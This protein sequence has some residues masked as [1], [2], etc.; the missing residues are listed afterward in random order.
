[1]SLHLNVWAF[2]VDEPGSRASAL[3][4]VSV[5][6]KPHIG[7]SFENVQSDHFRCFERS[8][9]RAERLFSAGVNAS[10]CSLQQGLR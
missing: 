4:N 1:M 2:L 6:S 9:M 10:R 3:L 7:G 5:F 8:V